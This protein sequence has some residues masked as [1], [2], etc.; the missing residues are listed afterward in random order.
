MTTPNGTTSSDFEV[1]NEVDQDEDLVED[2]IGD[3]GDGDD[4][5]DDVEGW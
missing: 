5:D 1:G 2:V 3:D 4:E